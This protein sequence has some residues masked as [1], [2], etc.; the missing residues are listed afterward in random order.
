MV[1][2]INVDDLV[3]LRGMVAGSADK[4]RHNQHLVH[5]AKP[6]GQVKPIWNGHPIW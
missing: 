2:T 1:S 6:L 3:L 5:R 4:M